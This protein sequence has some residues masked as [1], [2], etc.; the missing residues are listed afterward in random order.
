MFWVHASN[1]ARFE[2]SFRDLADCVNMTG[3]NDQRVNIFKLVHDWLY[4]LKRKWLLILDNIDDSQFILQVLNSHQT[5]TAESATA[6]R[7]LREYIPQC[8][9]GSVLITTRNKGVA[10]QLVNQHDTVVVEP[11]SDEQALALFKKK[12]GVLEDNDNVAAL[13]AALEYMPLAIVQAAAYISQRTPRCS[14]MQYFDEFRRSDREKTNLLDYEAGQL[15]RDREA[16]NSIIITWQISFE[17][18]RQ[19]KPSAAD[20]LSLMSFFDR[21]GIPESLIYNGLETNWVKEASGGRERSIRQHLKHLLRH[22]RKKPKAQQDKKEGNSDKRR[23][24]DDVM[25]LRDLCFI[26]VMEDGTTFEMHSLI[27]LATRRWLVENGKFEWWKKQFV[28]NL[29]EAFPTGEYENWPT[30]QVLFA[31]AKSAVEQQPQENSSLAEWATLLYHAAWYSEMVGN[32]TDAI[33]LS[34][35]S[36]KARKKVLGL[37]H[38]DTLCSIGMVAL[39]YKLAGRWNAAEELEVQVMETRKKKLGA[40]HPDTLTSMANLASTYQDQGRWDA[41]EELEVQVIETFKKK[42]GADYPD[43]LTSIANLAL[44]L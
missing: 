42:L 16:K 9:R 30:C 34:E 11:M 1:A 8:K 35:I 12:L 3:R 22:T 44:T 13:A 32:I 5:P 41:A 14:V 39:A 6:A 7:P 38:E 33:T 17:H 4:A 27:Q 28:S 2:Q 26:S 20:L 43:T 31:H 19:T 24:E 40:D 29:S 36:M 25:A 23:F 18:L 37:K 10:L 15:R 21:Q